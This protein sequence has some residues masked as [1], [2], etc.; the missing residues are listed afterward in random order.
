MVCCR[1]RLICSRTGCRWLTQ[2]RCSGR[3]LSKTWPPVVCWVT[4][5]FPA[6]YRRPVPAPLAGETGLLQGCAGPSAAGQRC[7]R[8]ACLASGSVPLVWRWC[9]VGTLWSWPRGSVLRSPA[10]LFLLQ[11][12]GRVLIRVRFRIAFV[13]FCDESRGGAPQDVG[14]GKELWPRPQGHGQRSRKAR[15]R[16]PAQRLLP[17]TGGHGVERGLADSSA[18]HPARD[19]LQKTKTPQQQRPK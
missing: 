12:Q 11:P 9:P 10:L 7:G 2:A 19:R 6:P 13:C 15:G 17:S 18:L 1:G 3:H 8:L 5:S 4:G 14:A 16:H